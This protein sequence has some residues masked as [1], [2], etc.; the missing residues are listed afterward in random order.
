MHKIFKNLIIL[1]LAAAM[2]SACVGINE[3]KT[4]KKKVLKKLDDQLADRKASEIEHV[5][6]EAFQGDGVTEFAAEIEEESDGESDDEFNENKDKKAQKKSRKSI[7]GDIKKAIESENGEE[8]ES[9]SEEEDAEYEIAEEPDEIKGESSA[10]GK[11][12]LKSD[13]GADDDYL[14]LKQAEKILKTAADTTDYPIKILENETGE[15]IVGLLDED[16]CGLPEVADYNQAL[17]EIF[18]FLESVPYS[19]AE[20]RVATFD[21]AA[22]EI[23]SLHSIFLHGGNGRSYHFTINLL[24]DESGEILEA[25]TLERLAEISAVK[26]FDKA[27]TLLCSYLAALQGACLYSYDLSTGAFEDLTGAEMRKS[28]TAATL[29]NY[30]LSKEHGELRCYLSAETL[31]PVVITE[32]G[33]S[34]YGSAG[35]TVEIVLTDDL[36]SFARLNISAN[37]VLLRIDLNEAEAAGFDTGYINKKNFKNYLNLGAKDLREVFISRESEFPLEI[38]RDDDEYE[39]LYS[40][41]ISLDDPLYLEAAYPSKGGRY[42]YED[43]ILTGI[44]FPD[45]SLE[46]RRLHGLEDEI[47]NIFYLTV[48]GPY[49][50]QV[51]EWS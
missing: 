8:P 21:S 29:K 3:E 12:E 43:L 19:E 13:S 24:L 47:Y 32:L 9:V 44:A 37:T 1:L 38:Y 33:E 36:L 18:E 30:E 11:D 41:Q 22:G 39:N 25:L 46:K 27:E 48:I 42:N 35:Q 23:L 20:T 2:L 51:P 45:E 7:T 31:L 17:Y 26:N 16:F 15:M 6:D 50:N 10:E 34:F 14:S 49:P 5:S 28:E 4:G 40:A